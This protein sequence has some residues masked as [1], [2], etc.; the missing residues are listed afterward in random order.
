M[1][2]LNLQN[3]NQIQKKTLVLDYDNYKFLDNHDKFYNDIEDLLQLNNNYLQMKFDFTIEFY[4]E[5]D[6]EFQDLKSFIFNNTLFHEFKK[7]ML[8]KQI[9]Q[10]VYDFNDGFP[11]EAHIWLIQ[12]V[13]IMISID[14]DKEKSE[15]NILNNVFNVIYTKVITINQ[16]FLISSK[17]F[18]NFINENKNKTP[19]QIIDNYNQLPDLPRNHEVI[20]LQIGSLNLPQY[21]NPII[22]TIYDIMQNKGIEC[23]EDKNTFTIY[24]TILRNVYSQKLITSNKLFYNTYFYHKI[25]IDKKFYYLEQLKTLGNIDDMFDNNI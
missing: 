11:N 13:K 6:L 1:S 16:S 23:R 2:E 10:T 22:I 3:Q 18:L 5:E 12:K 14:Q 8:K 17:I 20:I 7:L 24:Q 25:Y 9:T 4:Y 21:N 19:H 15:N